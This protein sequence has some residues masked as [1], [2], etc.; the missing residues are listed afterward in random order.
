[1]SQFRTT[2]NERFDHAPGCPSGHRL[3][4]PRLALS[5]S[6]HLPPTTTACRPASL[7]APPQG[8]PLRLGARPQ[9]PMSSATSL[10]QRT[11]TPS[12]RRLTRKDSDPENGPVHGV[13]LQQLGG[14]AEDQLGYLRA[15]RRLKLAQLFEHSRKLYEVSAGAFPPQA[16]PPKLLE[17]ITREATLEDDDTLSAMWASLLAS[18]A[19]PEGVRGIQPHF[20]SI[21]A[22]L[23]PQAA[24]V[25]DMMYVRALGHGDRRPIRPSKIRGRCDLSVEEHERVIDYLLTAGLVRVPSDI[26]VVARVGV[27]GP[28][29]ATE[30]KTTRLALVLTATGFDFVEACRRGQPPA[31]PVADDEDAA[32]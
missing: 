28:P 23:S 31:D 16:V 15:R 6:E 13:H 20:P 11:I 9:P 26:F 14:L 5:G 25:L 21:L 19:H 18:A 7:Y 30:D 12:W 1:M 22:G 4:R 3:P 24:R 29:G 10:P 32:E 8:A 27:G 17:P 2:N